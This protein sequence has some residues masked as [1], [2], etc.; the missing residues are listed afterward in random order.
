M[1]NGRA[2]RAVGVALLA[3][4]VAGTAGC[5]RIAEL[6]DG[7]RRSSRESWEQGRRRIGGRAGLAAP[8]TG[9]PDAHP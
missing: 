2:V 1:R 7:I 5:E 3:L 9:A 8:L 4:A 6:V